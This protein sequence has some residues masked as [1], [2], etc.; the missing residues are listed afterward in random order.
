MFFA[1][2]YSAN[3][4]PGAW[5]EKLVQK[6]EH[7][8]TQIERI[9]LVKYVCRRFKLSWDSALYQSLLCSCEP[10]SS[11][12][13]IL[14]LFYLSATAFRLFQS[15]SS[16][17]KARAIVTKVTKPRTIKTL[18]CRAFAQAVP[19]IPPKNT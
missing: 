8:L 4:P 11:V 10:E 2:L 12:V 9:E 5:V 17:P 3:T 19:R 1:I 6:S 7:F 15:V 14:T 13:H 16:A 18:V